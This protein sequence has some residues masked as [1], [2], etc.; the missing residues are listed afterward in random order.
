MKSGLTTG[1]DLIRKCPSELIVC[2]DGL[3]TGFVKDGISFAYTEIVLVFW[4]MRKLLREPQR[5]WTGGEGWIEGDRCQQGAL[6]WQL[7][8]RFV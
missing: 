5:G 3:K 6:K 8:F 4:E 7:R 2:L 1:E